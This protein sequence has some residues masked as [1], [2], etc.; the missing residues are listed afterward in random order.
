M[1][2]LY[3][4]GQI[5]RTWATDSCIFLIKEKCL[6]EWS[7]SYAPKATEKEVGTSA[8]TNKG[9]DTRT[10]ELSLVGPNPLSLG[11]LPCWCW[12][13]FLQIRTHKL[14]RKKSQYK[15]K[16]KGPP[17]RPKSKKGKKKTKK[18][19]KRRLM[20]GLKEKCMRKWYATKYR[21]VAEYKSSVEWFWQ[22][23]A[24]WV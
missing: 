17:R 11:H 3:A 21:S 12:C 24:N 22:N 6:G 1:P 20:P 16:P 15:A 19:P 8:L 9:G 2:D 13:S 14:M 10:Q 5:Q 23:K 18:K 7:N 4:Y